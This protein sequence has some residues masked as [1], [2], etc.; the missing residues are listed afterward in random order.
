MGHVILEAVEILVS[1]LAYLA[2]VWLFLFH[3]HDSR[4]WCLGIGVDNRV[5][6]IP[7]V[8][9]TLVVVSVLAFSV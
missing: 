9:K 3:A 5:G 8:M 4:I 7:I 1:L 6:A 2:L